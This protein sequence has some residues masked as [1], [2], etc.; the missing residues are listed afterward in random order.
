MHKLLK[1][2][3]YKPRTGQVVKCQLCG[4]DVYKSPHHAKNYKTHFCSKKCS[5]LYLKDRAFSFNCVICGNVVKTQPCQIKLRNRKTCSLKCRGLYKT[6]IA[7]EK[8][9]DGLMTKHQI[10][11]AMRYCKE[12]QDWRTAIFKRD[13]YTCQICGVR[14]TYLEADHIKP[15][16]FFPELRFEMSNG[17]TLCKKCHNKTKMS[18][19]KL[20]EI[21]VSEK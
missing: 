1:S 18:A 2:K 8:H 16:A 4:V 12:A 11:R 20:R 17:R 6:K 5:L 13:D 19:K 7:R 9:S 15:W 3:G 10:D 21:W 14:G